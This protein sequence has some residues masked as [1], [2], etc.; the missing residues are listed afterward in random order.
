MLF[1]MYMLNMYE[2]DGIVT[3]SQAFT[4]GSFIDMLLITMTDH[5]RFGVD[6]YK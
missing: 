6:L 5:D 1:E 2:S 4:F 3:T